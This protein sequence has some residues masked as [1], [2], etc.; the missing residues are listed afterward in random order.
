LIFYSYAVADILLNFGVNASQ[1][2]DK[3]RWKGRE[4]WG[5]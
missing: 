1:E 4:D 2:G 3:Y 5:Q